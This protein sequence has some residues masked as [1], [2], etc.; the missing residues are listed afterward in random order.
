MLCSP[1]CGR[2]IQQLLD[3]SGGHIAQIHQDRSWIQARR[4]KSSLG[5]HGV[6]NHTLVVKEVG[7]LQHNA[8]Q[9]ATLPSTIFSGSRT[10][11]TKTKKVLTLFTWMEWAS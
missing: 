7:V 3:C 4:S 5:A 2:R 10:I 11:L 1:L 8:L 6:G 9:R